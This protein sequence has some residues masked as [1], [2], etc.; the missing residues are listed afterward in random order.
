MTFFSPGQVIST[1]TTDAAP[2]GSWL[3]IH[4]DFLLHYPL[5]KN[6]KK[7]VYFSYAVHEALHLSENEEL[8]VE[9]IMNN[10]RQEY[11]SVIDG[12]SQDVIISRIELLLNYCNRFTTGNLLPVNMPATS[13]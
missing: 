13:C 8:M 4:P 3:V 1:K 9:T 2:N 6:I 5:S 10:I 7:Y 11:R 12:Y